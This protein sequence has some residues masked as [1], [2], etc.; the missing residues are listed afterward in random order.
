MMG[1]FRV[2]LAAG[3]YDHHDPIEAAKPQHDYDDDEPD[4]S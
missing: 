4:E 2:G 1:Q 3:E